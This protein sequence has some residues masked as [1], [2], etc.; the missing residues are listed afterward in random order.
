M[1]R[2]W[3]IRN[4]NAGRGFA[5]IAGATER[6][7]RRQGAACDT[8]VTRSLD[9]LDAVIAE[10]ERAQPDVLAIAGGDGAVRALA[11]RLGDD[12]PPL[13]VLAGGGGN[14]IA[15]ELGLPQNG[16]GMAAR[17]LAGVTTHITVGRAAGADQAA[18]AFALMAGVGLDGVAAASTPGPIKRLS[19]HTAYGLAIAGAAGSMMAN[20]CDLTV[21]IDGETVTA[22]WV[23]V[24]NARLAS[25]QYRQPAGDPRLYA[26]IVR[27]RGPG[28]LIDILMRL[29]RRRLAPTAALEIRPCRSLMVTS[30]AGLPI[31]GDGEVIGQTPAR[32]EPWRSLRVIV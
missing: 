32:L 9:A 18:A 11:E 4:A 16:A 29:A 12:A 7:L 25:P 26:A 14:Y 27:P 23:M 21:A 5:P 8:L 24:T 3:I 30:P 10:V 28:D 1:T 15:R 31:H 22:P 13:A 19:A 17:I 6:A 20:A 2:V